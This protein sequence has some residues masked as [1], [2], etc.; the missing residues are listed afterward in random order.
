MMRRKIPIW[1]AVAMCAAAAWPQ[2]AEFAPVI[3]KPASRTVDLPGEIRPFLA[4]SLHAKVAGY[5]ERVLVDR[6]SMVKEGD[7]LAALSAPE[8]DA[9]IAEAQSKF[10]AAE[11][12]RLQAEAQQAAVESTAEGIAAAAKTPGAVAGNDLVQAQQQVEAAKALVTSRQRASAAAH[13][14]IEAQQ[15]MQAYLKITA[16]FAGVVTERFVH[17]GALVGPGNDQPLLALQQVSHLRVVAPVPEED[18]SGIAPGAKVEF[19]VPAYPHR[20]YSG[21]IARVAHAVDQATRTMPVELDA[22][23]PDGTLAPGM[24]AS[25]KWPVRGAAAELW[26]P[27]TSIVTTTERSFVIRNASG[28]AQWVDVKKGTAEGDLIEVIGDLHAGDMVVRRATDE[29]RNGAALQARAK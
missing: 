18:V 1:A 28:K 6:G 14:A 13:S 10:Q 4:V 8:I 2:T 26:V 27:K 9:Q 22:L 23:N 25:V 21:T 15:A 7:L 12:D 24:Y 11:A 20:T 29:I 5:V 17:P 16:P 3:L 19:S